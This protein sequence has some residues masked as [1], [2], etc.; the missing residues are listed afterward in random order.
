VQPV[1][2]APELGGEAGCVCGGGGVS[3]ATPSA[4]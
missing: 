3:Q 1:V 4:W 2:S